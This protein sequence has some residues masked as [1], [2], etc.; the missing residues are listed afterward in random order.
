MKSNAFHLRTFAA[1]RLCVRFFPSFLIAQQAVARIGSFSAWSDRDSCMTNTEVSHFTVR[2][3]SSEPFQELFTLSDEEL[4]KRRAK[5]YVADSECRFPCLVSLQD[6]ETWGELVLIYFSHR[7]GDS[8][9]PVT[10][11]VFVTEEVT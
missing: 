6:S 4:E 10:H 1:L 2:A 11:S 3:L 7:P 9:D 8:T 5:R